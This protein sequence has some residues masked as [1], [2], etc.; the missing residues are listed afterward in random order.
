MTFCFDTY[1]QLKISEQVRDLERLCGKLQYRL[2]LYCTLT[3]VFQSQ[4]LGV[5]LHTR[6]FNQKYQ[7]DETSFDILLR[8]QILWY[9]NSIR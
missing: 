1:Y 3:T 8:N 6:L 9:Y 2:N 5:R 4:V 7:Y